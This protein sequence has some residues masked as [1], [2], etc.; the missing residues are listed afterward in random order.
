MPTELN[1][2][3]SLGLSRIR[4]PKAL[5]AEVGWKADSDAF[6]AV[7]ILTTPGELLCTARS[8][9][10]EN[11]EHPFREAL[12][13]RDAPAL[14]EGWTDRGAPGKRFVLAFR[15]FEFE[16]RWTTDA[17]AQLD[18]S[19]G[20]AI[21]RLCGWANPESNPPLYAAIRS[22]VLA[23]LSSERMMSLLL[24]QPLAP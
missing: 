21:V 11:Q 19:V 8:S 22:N 5:V 1:F 4:I 2:S 10:D 13:L 16:A 17:R 6:M 23:L 15:V 14:L 3:A 18:L 24:Q 7:G 9:I 20:A 12:E